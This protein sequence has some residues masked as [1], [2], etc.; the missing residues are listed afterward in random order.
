MFEIVIGIAWIVSLTTIVLGFG[1]L[2]FFETYFGLDERRYELSR[3]RRA[4]K[5]AQ[6]NSAKI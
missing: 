6:K 1:L 5:Q 3:R 2:S 4:D